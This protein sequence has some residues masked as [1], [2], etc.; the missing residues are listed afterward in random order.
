[1]NKTLRM[2]LGVVL[3]GAFVGSAIAQ[4]QFPDVPE[5]HWAYEALA[6][7]KKNGLLVGY[8]DGLFRG[9]RPA[10][11]YE[12][13]VAIHATYQYLKN[14]TDGLNAEIEKI[15]GNTGGVGYN[16]GPIKDALAA[17]QR[18]VAAMKGWGDDIANLKRMSATFEK[19]LA[20]LGVDVEAMKKD[21][22]DLN[23]RV[24]K[25]EKNALPITVHGDV[26][27]FMAAGASG[28]AGGARTA[29]LTVDGRPVGMMANGRLVGMEEDLSVFHEANLKI[30]GTNEEGPKW[31]ATM[32]IGNIFGAGGYQPGFTQ[33][34]N[35]R[36]AGNTN[37]VFTEAV[38]EFDTSMMGQGVSAKVGRF[39]WKTSHYIF[40]RPDTSPY[41]S[42]EGWDNRMHT[43]DGA[44]L[45]FN[46]GS[47]KLAVVLGRTNSGQAGTGAGTSLS[48][49]MIGA[50]GITNAFGGYGLAG[51]AGFLAD[52][53][54]GFDLGVPLGENGNL[55]LSY[56]FH[57]ARRDTMPAGAN[58][59]QVFG[60]ELGWGFGENVKLDAGYA[61]SNTFNGNGSVIKRNNYAWHVKVNYETEKW[62][63]G[64]GFREIMPDYMA[65]GDW[66]R[67]G[68]WWNP[69]D[70][71]GFHVGGHFNLSEALTL[72]AKGEFYEGTSKAS[73][74]TAANL[75]SGDKL[76]RYVID[77]GYTINESWN[78]MLGLENV[79]FRPNGGGPKPFQ[80]WYNIG[81]GW[82]MSDMAKLNLLWQISDADTRTGLPG[83]RNRGSLLTT[84]LSIKF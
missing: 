15:K 74:R 21:L 23:D 52:N 48:S 59:A 26:N 29:G 31:R 55:N 68:T 34:G 49:V 20:S 9:G 43:I 64:V 16:D 4:D 79:D 32:Q 3:M 22:K 71:R 33:G 38:A 70:I 36:D 35:F 80:R 46:F 84:Q 81:L 66:G 14:I 30:A 47:A 45:G 65:A 27:F 54:L 2:A 39:G 19:E 28:K 76:N 40:Q 7:M 58:R 56:L 13:A 77:L 53:M 37:I 60:A 50:G 61:Q 24:T 25:L 82:K 44:Q 1:M 62:G 6:N 17:L 67:I 83:S 11:R 42:Q 41:Y 18:D 5:N 73:A 75:V 51:G 57:T 72:G 63:I 8:P 10:T 78:A 12:M 69:T